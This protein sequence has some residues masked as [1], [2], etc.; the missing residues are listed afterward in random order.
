VRVE[1]LTDWPDDVA[2]GTSVHPE[3]D[4]EPLVIDRIERGGRI[5]VLYFTG[6]ETRESVEPLTGRYLEA[7]AHE[8]D[9]GSYFWSDLIGLRV[10]E[11]GGDPIGELVEI[12]RTGGNEVYR[13]VGPAGERLVPA[14][15]S[16]VLEIDLDAGRIVVAPD[17]AETVG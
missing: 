14:L 16:A 5:P 11:A 17:D 8:L 10:E 13:V 7:P 3:G 6:H 1:I 2:A 15:R 12:F 9:E 4:T